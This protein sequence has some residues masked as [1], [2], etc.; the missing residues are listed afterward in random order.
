MAQ[1]IIISI[2][3]IGVFCFGF[4]L[5]ILIHRFIK[6]IQKRIKKRKMLDMV[7]GSFDNVVN[8]G[9][10]Y[11]LHSKKLNQYFSFSPDNGMISQSVKDNK[12]RCDLLDK[13]IK[14]IRETIKFIEKNS[15]QIKEKDRALTA[16]RPAV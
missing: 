3:W 7:F 5:W 10:N 6:K 11:L 1:Y 8:D 4:G 9:E 15:K 14:S 16:G 2:F 12:K 13:E